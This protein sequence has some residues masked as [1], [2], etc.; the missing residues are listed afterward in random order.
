MIR[1]HSQYFRN[2]GVVNDGHAVLG[3]QR[4]HECLAIGCG[5]LEAEMERP[6][7]RQRK[8]LDEIL[9][10]NLEVIC[11]LRHEEGVWV[12]FRLATVALDVVKAPHTSVHFRNCSAELPHDSASTQRPRGMGPYHG[13]KWRN[14]ASWK[15]K[16]AI[17]RCVYVVATSL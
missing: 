1:T 13:R 2:N 15:A 4:I 7:A 10:Q 9:Q 6:R 11:G 17:F 5:D 16:Q 3:T 12:R 14:F 8:D